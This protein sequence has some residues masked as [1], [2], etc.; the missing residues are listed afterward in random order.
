M[1]INLIHCL[2]AEGNSF[3]LL[4]SDGDFRKYYGVSCATEFTT[5]K[6]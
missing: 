5:K 6:P 1:E 3:Y 4:P 2:V